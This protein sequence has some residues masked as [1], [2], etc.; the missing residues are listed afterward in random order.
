MPLVFEGFDASPGF[1]TVGAA[2]AVS[3]GFAQPSAT[4]TDCGGYSNTDMGSSDHHVEALLV[5][6]ADTT[7]V[8]VSIIARWDGIDPNLGGDGYVFQQNFADAVLYSANS[9]T[10]NTLATITNAFATPGEYKLRLEVSGS[11]ISAKINDAHIAGSPFTDTAVTTGTK[12]GITMYCNDLV[13][14]SQF[15]WFEAGTPAAPSDA[16]PPTWDYRSA[17]PRR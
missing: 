14:D 2:I 9:S 3:G 17:V 11:T 15:A 4:A 5:T 6:T 7:D 16:P 13:T 10:F 12:A 1:T 8:Y